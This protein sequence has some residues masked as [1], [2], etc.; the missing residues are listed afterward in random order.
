MTR[1]I[2]GQNWFPQIFGDLFDSA[3]ASRAQISTPAMNVKQTA[4]G[5]E[6][7][8][9]APGMTREDLSIR[10]DHQ[11]RLVIAMERTSATDSAEGGEQEE[12]YI[13]KEFTLQRFTKTL[14]LP[15]DVKKE[16]IAATMKD[17]ILKVVLPRLGEEDK[18]CLER[19][20][21]I[22]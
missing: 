5:Y 17:G 19:Q 1:N 12:R 4:E 18:K 3:I 22:S 13:R 10:L 15:D 9:L 6:I 2:L 11:D 8:L 20:I 16:E 7:E 14:M 21:L